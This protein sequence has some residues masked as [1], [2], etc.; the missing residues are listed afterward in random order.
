MAE[1]SHEQETIQSFPMAENRAIV[2]QE[3]NGDKQSGLSFVKNVEDLVY[4]SIVP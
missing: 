2:S 4:E 3:N 1:H